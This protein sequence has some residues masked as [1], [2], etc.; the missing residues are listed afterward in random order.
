[1]KSGDPE[2]L[3]LRGP[4]AFVPLCPDEFSRSSATS[5]SVEDQ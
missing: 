2:A 3:P 4:H 1:M 5:H